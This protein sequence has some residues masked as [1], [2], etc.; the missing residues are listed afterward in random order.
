[1]ERAIKIATRGSKLALKQF[2]IISK[3]LESAGFRA[4]PVIVQSHAEHD[5][6]T[7]LYLMKEQGVFV[8]RLNDKILEGKVDA[9]VHSAKDIPS[10]ID[11]G[12]AISYFSKRAD[13]RDYFVSSSDISLFSGTVGSSSIRRK[14]FLSIFNRNLRF[15]NIRGNIDTRIR[16]WEEGKV[17]ALVVAKAALDRLGL[18]PPGMPIPEEICPPDPNQGFIAV[19]T[20]KGS[21]LEKRMR[22]VQDSQ[23]LWEATAEREL[24]VRLHSGCSQAIS[25]RAEYKGRAIKFAFAKEGRRFDLIFKGKVEESEVKKMRDLIDS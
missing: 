21:E 5:A 20:T 1:M 23:A 7:P 10:E 25:I 15:E 11:P 2:E 24:T 19:V 14:E 18:I 12:L 3:E 8:K 6:E 17:G 13:P 22:K 16:K 4:E 9:A